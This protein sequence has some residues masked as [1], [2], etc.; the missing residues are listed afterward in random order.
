MKPR[1]RRRQALLQADRAPLGDALLDLRRREEQHRARPR[2]ALAAAERLP[3]RAA[4]R[5]AVG[6]L[7][8][9]VAVDRGAQRRVAAHVD[10]DR[11]LAG[12]QRRHVVV[13]DARR[14]S[15]RGPRVNAELAGDVRPMTSGMPGSPRRCARQK[16][17]P[18]RGLARRARDQHRRRAEEGV[19]GEEVVDQERGDEQRPQQRRRPSCSGRYS[20]IAAAAQVAGCRPRQ[21][22]AGAARRRR[23]PRATMRA[24]RSTTCVGHRPVAVEALARRRRRRRSDSI[25]V[26][27]PHTGMQPQSRLAGR[28]ELPVVHR[29]A[30]GAVGDVVRRSARSGRCAG[31]PRPAE[32]RPA[33]HRATA[34]GADRRGRR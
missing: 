18:V 27:K 3:V 1:Q 19:V 29:L 9:A 12:R 24:G 23:S 26:A 16:A 32:R 14:R 11:A 8:A 21:A 15:S 4:D 10:V 2:Q 25:T 6:E 28:E 34:F 5:A 13:G 20:R 31:A 17:E 30:E 33:A 22:R 7:V